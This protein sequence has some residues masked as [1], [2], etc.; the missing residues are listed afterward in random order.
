METS[1]RLGTR[2]WGVKESV[3][4]SGVKK[5]NGQTT[6]SKQSTVGFPNARGL[7]SCDLTRTKPGNAVKN[8]PPPSGMYTPLPH[9]HVKH[10]ETP[11]VIIDV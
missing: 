9:P 5:P 10:L 2:G 3:L 1:E 8:S 7:R 11:T 4:D 6:P